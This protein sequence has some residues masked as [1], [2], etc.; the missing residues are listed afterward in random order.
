M[1]T[2]HP[3]G[4]ASAGC[5][6]FGPRTCDTSLAANPWVTFSGG[7]TQGGV[8]MSSPWDGDL[9]SFPGG[10]HYALVHGLPSPPA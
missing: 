7:E 6:T 4:A 8:Y 5:E 10:M 3:G 2:R 9:L 1:R